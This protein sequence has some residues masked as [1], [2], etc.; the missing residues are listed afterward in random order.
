MRPHAGALCFIA[1]LGL[2]PGHR[3]R[4]Q[5][6]KAKR[7]GPPLWVP[8]LLTEPLALGA[9]YASTVDSAGD[10]AVAVTFAVSGLIATALPLL[11]DEPPELLIPYGMGLLGIAYYNV[12]NGDAHTDSR[13]S[14]TN[15]V[16]TNAVAAV[17]FASAAILSHENS[18]IDPR[19]GFNV[20]GSRHGVILAYRF[21]W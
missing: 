17:A 3:A 13:K 5:D 12:R 10:E 4:A 21:S 18:V 14:W 15:F 11:G 19:S 9:G 1:L 16:A 2:V 6:G 8:I 20:Q 7:V